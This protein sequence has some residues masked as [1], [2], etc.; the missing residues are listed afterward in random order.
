MSKLPE[1]TDGQAQCLRL[2]AQGYTSKEIARTLGIS[3]H[4]VDQRLDRA[5]AALGAADRAAAARLFI[6]REGLSDRVVY[7]APNLAAAAPGP[8]QTGL[9]DQTASGGAAVMVREAQAVYHATSPRYSLRL[10]FA[11]RREERNELGA[12]QR[13]G[14]ILAIA[15]AVPTLLGSLI[16]GL[17]SLVEFVA[18]L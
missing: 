12:A 15:V 17:D 5:R 1:V 8:A 13:L 11:R 9:P 7:D 3:K 4:T 18:G 14:W 2:V 16:Q 10:P 6:A